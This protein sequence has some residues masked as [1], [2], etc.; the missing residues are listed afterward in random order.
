MSL[1][2]ANQYNVNQTI[3][4]IPPMLF[5]SL[6]YNVLFDAAQ[7]KLLM[8]VNKSDVQ[9]YITLSFCTNRFIFHHFTNALFWYVLLII[10]I[11]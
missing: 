9:Y 2:N 8:I 11:N 5:Y 4:L 10:V 7:G 6:I 3:L 1:K